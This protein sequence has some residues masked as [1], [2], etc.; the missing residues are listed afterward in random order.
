MIALASPITHLLRSSAAGFGPAEKV[1]KNAAEWRGN[2]DDTRR[3]QGDD[4][5]GFY[6]GRHR[7]IQAPTGPRGFLGAMVRP[8][9]AAHAGS[10]KSGQGRKRQSK[11]RED[12]Y[13]RASSDS[14]S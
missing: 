8:V 11:T 7:G 6:A 13:R 14:G 9:Q 12:E 5:A 3:G 4:H 1:F 10:R 2:S